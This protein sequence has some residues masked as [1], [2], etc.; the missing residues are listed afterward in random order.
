VLSAARGGRRGIVDGHRQFAEVSGPFQHGRYRDQ[1]RGGGL[2]RPITGVGTKKEQLISPDR[3]PDGAPKLVLLVHWLDAGEK[4][5]RVEVAVADVFV[6]QA[7]ELVGAGLD[8]IVSRTLPAKL[9]RG[10]GRLQLELVHGF[11][12]DAQR[13]VADL[14]LQHGGGGGETVDI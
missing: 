3:P 4:S 13:K 7:V 8:Y 11:D 10:A 6:G 9:H 14:A 12:G 1:R 2:N 5:A